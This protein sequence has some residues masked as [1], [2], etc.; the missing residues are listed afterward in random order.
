MKLLGKLDNVQKKIL[1]I[2]I[3]IIGSGLLIYAIMTISQYDFFCPFYKMSG[4]YCPG[5]GLTRSCMRLIHL[6]FYHSFR[7]HPAFF[8]GAVV[9]IIISIF[10]FIGKPKCFRNSKVNL[11]IMYITLGLYIAFAILRNIPGFEFLQPVDPV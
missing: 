10:A 2:Y 5:C 7:N 1:I 11:T 4:I 6:D 8:V 3:A 9:W